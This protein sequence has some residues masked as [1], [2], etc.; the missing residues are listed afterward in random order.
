MRR[1]LGILTIIIWLGS[2]ILLWREWQPVRCRDRA[3]V[4]P[5]NWLIG[6]CVP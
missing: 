6:G 2:L 1:F 5:L 4:E 3:I